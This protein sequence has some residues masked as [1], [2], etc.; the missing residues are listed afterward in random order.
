M[1]EKQTEIVQT[2]KKK[3][4]YNPIVPALQQ[5]L[6]VLA[7]LAENQPNMTIKEICEHLQ[8]SKS[9]A[10]TLLNTLKQYDYVRQ[11]AR[12][13]TYSLWLGIVRMGRNVLNNLDVKDLCSPF[14]SELAEQT[15]CRVHMGIISGERFYIVAR[16][17]A[18]GTLGF[19]LEQYDYLHLTHGAHGKAIVAFLPEKEQGEIL[20]GDSL[21]FYG[22]D[23]PVDFK[24]LQEEMKECREIG[25][26]MDPG[27]TTHGINVVAAPVFNVIDNVYGAVVLLGTFPRS[28]IKQ[29]GIQVA[30]TAH[31]IS[32]M[33]G[34]NI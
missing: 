9:R 27:E 29:N 11:D 6:N 12:N 4:T 2:I 10:Y 24:N 1:S 16:S 3:S 8:I 31:L 26:A 25:Y 21:A 13:K 15:H 14:L 5:G 22:D 18:K 33:L 19:S 7:C 28:Q 17:E 30:K 34:A 23:N 32:K 20:S